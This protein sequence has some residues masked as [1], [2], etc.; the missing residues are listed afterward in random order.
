MGAKKKEVSDHTKLDPGDTLW[1]FTHEATKSSCRVIAK[2]W[3]A[4]NAKALA[5]LGAEPGSLT[6]EAK[7]GLHKK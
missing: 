6:W 7:E 2:T 1:E 3:Y 5:L 4:G